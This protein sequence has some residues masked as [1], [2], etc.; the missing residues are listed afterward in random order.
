MGDGMAAQKQELIIFHADSL[1]APFKEVTAAF[2]SKYPNALVKLEAAGSRES[3]SKISSR[4]RPCDVLGCDDYGAIA[5]LTPRHAD[6]NIGFATHELAIAFR[7]KSQQAKVITS[8]NWPDILLRNDVHFGRLAYSDLCGLRT[9]L[10]FQLAE[11]YYK[12][13][14]LASKLSE[15]DG[16]RFVRSNEAALLALLESGQIDYAF[17]YGSAIEQHNLKL[18]RLPQQINLG[19]LNQA[20]YYKQAK[21]NVGGP[22]LGKTTVVRGEPIVC[23]VTIPNNSPNPELAEAWVGFLLSTGGRDILKKC[24]QSSLSPAPTDGYSKL[25]EHL[26]PF[27]SRIGLR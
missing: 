8:R 7:D 9:A 13:P 24:G 27:C 6:F 3:A 14:S 16:T 15:K 5:G 11:K 23:S 17:L 1:T 22:R 12:T 10:V 2:N 20:E 26:K 25:P 4:G 18:L 19:S 21:T